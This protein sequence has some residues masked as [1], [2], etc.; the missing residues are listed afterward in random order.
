MNYGL[1]LSAAGTLANMHRQDV[2]AN[3]L[4]N[5]STVG[6]K[7]SVAALKQR[8]PEAVEDRLSPDMSHKLLE[9]LGGGV[10]QMPTRLDGGQGPLSTTGNDLDLAIE[11][12]GFFAVRSGDQ[13]QLTRD[14]RFTL[15]HDNRIVTST[16]G[17]PLLDVNG[18]PITLDPHQ[19]VHI[20]GKGFVNQNGSEVARIRLVD[21]G[22]VSKVKHEGHG[23]Y[24]VNGGIP[25]DAGFAQG[26]IRQGAVEESNV[27]PVQ[28]LMRLTKAT[29]S[30]SSSANLI[31]YHDSIMDKAAN[32]LGRVA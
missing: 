9:K 18:Q 27:D 14:G 22:D 5:A 8:A 11:G 10:L 1:Y 24:S 29:K 4:T 17:Q 3:N 28:T 30:V 12:S 32:T 21:P 31:R 7:R 26:S 20:D 16:S 2:A 23:L 25:E 6:F 15:S 13:T 19:K